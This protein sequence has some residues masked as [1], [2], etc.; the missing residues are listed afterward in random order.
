MAKVARWGHPRGPG[1]TRQPRFGAR[2]RPPMAKVGAPWGGTDSPTPRCARRTIQTLGRREGDWSPPSRRRGAGTRK[3]GALW[4]PVAHSSPRAAKAR[5]PAPATWQAA[6][7]SNTWT[8]PS[9]QALQGPQRGPTAQARRRGAPWG[10]PGPYLRPWSEEMPPPTRVW[11]VVAR[12]NVDR[13]T[14]NK[15]C[16]GERGAGGAYRGCIGGHFGPTSPRGPKEGG[17][18]GPGSKFAPRCSR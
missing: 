9:N 3:R 2:W 18:Q 12:L 5:W 4:A 14:P 15:A 6:P 1:R 11:G 8:S 13:Y 16:L 10:R 7:A 17:R